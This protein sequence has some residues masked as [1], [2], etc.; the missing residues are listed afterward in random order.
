MAHKVG[1]INNGVEITAK[2]IKTGKALY[3]YK[4]ISF[5]YTFQEMNFEKKMSV[6]ETIAD[7]LKLGDSLQIIV[8]S[9]NP[10]KVLIKHE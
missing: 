1:I 5:A 6:H 4:D 7:K 8:N 10:K 9:E 3:G 2:V